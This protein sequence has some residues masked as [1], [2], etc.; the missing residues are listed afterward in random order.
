MDTTFG[1]R[2]VLALASA[3]LITGMLIISVDAA[4]QASKATSGNRRAS[5]VIA[6]AEP[7][8]TP[9]GRTDLGGIGVGAESSDDVAGNSTTNSRTTT[10]TKPATDPG[11]TVPPKPGKYRFKATSGSAQGSE[12]EETTT[13][14]ESQGGSGGEVRQLEKTQGGPTG[15]MDNTVVWRKDGKFIE[16]TTTD[17]EDCDYNPDILQYKLP[18]AKD[19]SWDTDSSC[20]GSF[21]G[22]GGQ[23]QQVTVRVT[24]SARVLGLERVQVVGQQVDT[25]IIDSNSNV[26][27]S[28]ATGQQVF[29][30][31]GNSRENFSPKHGITVLTNGSFTGFGSS[32]SYRAEI[33]NLE[34][35]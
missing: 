15:N 29:T 10:D 4:G 33:L 9:E 17:G 35:E 23:K 16:K 21:P 25:W 22:P 1:E 26:T 30:F 31:S 7:G 19:S 3:I 32:G 13:T 6:T 27:V 2:I 20:T 8:T 24:G 12:S 18:L 5:G 28:D 34:P 14:I 11:A